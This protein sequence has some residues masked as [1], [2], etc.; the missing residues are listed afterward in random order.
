MIWWK[1]LHCLYPGQW[2]D[3]SQLQYGD[4]EQLEWWYVQITLPVLRKKVI[5]VKR[6]ELLNSS[7]MVAWIFASV[8]KSMLLVASSSIIIELRRRRA[9][10]IAINCLWPCEKFVP[11]ADTWVSREIEA[12]TSTVVVVVETE[13]L[14]SFRST[15]CRESGS[16]VSAAWL[17]ELD[18]GLSTIKWTLWRTSR[19][20][21][22]LYSPEYNLVSWEKNIK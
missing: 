4:D 17:A 21:A 22:S 7:R 20:S 15:V 6:R 5:P 1:I 12:F 11:P 3:R 9:R 8:A 14:L 13:S 16:E 19:H 10:A 18:S 2:A